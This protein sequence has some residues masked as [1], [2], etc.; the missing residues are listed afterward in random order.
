[1]LS[2]F[3]HT[4]TSLVLLSMVVSCQTTVDFP[5]S[6]QIEF[7]DVLFKEIGDALTPDS[8]IFIITFEDGDGDLGLDDR[9]TA[10]PFHS[11][12]FVPDKNGNPVTIKYLDS[13]EYVEQ[14]QLQPHVL[15]YRCTNWIEFPNIN[16]TII[17]DT[18]W[19]VPNPNRN[20]MDLE[21]FVKDNPGDE[22][23]PFDWV[24]DIPQPCGFPLNL[25]FPVLQDSG[26]NTPLEG[27][28]RYGFINLG[29]LPLFENKIMRVDIRIRDRSLNVS[30]TV[31]TGEFNLRD[32]QV[33]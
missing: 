27:T 3:A 31:T 19:F 8:L 2:N 33:Q 20:N 28:I 23:E 10:P 11:G 30:N 21:F 9:F 17:E 13:A 1:M 12:E 4:L 29:L 25:R 18:L 26:D 15:P 5:N 14:Y 16:G 24:T 22:F 7:Q 6:P 32:I